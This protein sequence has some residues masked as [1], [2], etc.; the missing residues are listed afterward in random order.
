MQLE[1]YREEYK[2]T[3]DHGRQGITFG[4]MT[5]DGAQNANYC[6]T[7]CT[8]NITSVVYPHIEDLIGGK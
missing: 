6:R 4:V 3:W 1:T 7:N 2:D 5:I 8:D